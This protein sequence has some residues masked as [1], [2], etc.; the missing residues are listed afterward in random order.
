MT[1]Q[2]EETPEQYFERLDRENGTNRALP[3]NRT[4]EETK[5]GIRAAID[6]FNKRVTGNPAIENY[7]A[8]IPEN[9]RR[10][11]R[12]FCEGF[13]RPPL[14]REDGY[15][16]K[17]WGEQYEL[18]LQPEDISGAIT[19]MRLDN[20]TIKSPQSVTAIAE[21]IKRKRLDKI[22]KPIQSGTVYTSPTSAKYI[23]GKNG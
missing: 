7:L 3:S 14:K 20:L 10:I 23:G 22:N 19:R 5:E 8:K 6:T 13:G 4:V 21:D 16:R 15:W 12:A 17:M 1:G 9:V 11:A 18:E 2:S